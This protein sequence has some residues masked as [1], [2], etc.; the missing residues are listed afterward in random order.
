MVMWDSPPVAAAYL[1]KKNLRNH[2]SFAFPYNPRTFDGFDR[3]PLEMPQKQNL[4]K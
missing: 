4:D 3:V 2:E 1:L